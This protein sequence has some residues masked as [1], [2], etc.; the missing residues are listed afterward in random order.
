MAR[1]AEL[2]LAHALRLEHDLTLLL[3]DTSDRAE[4]V[5]AFVE[6]RSPRFEGR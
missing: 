3:Q 5:R 4:G 2:P 6:R 1:G